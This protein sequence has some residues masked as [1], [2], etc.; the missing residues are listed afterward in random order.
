MHKLLGIICPENLNVN[1]IDRRPTECYSFHCLQLFCLRGP[2]S[3]AEKIQLYPAI[4][5]NINK[6]YWTDR[7]I[8]ETSRPLA[9]LHL[10]V[11]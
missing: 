5:R 9:R 4:V 10:S 6:L 7:S 3:T 11:S 8:I 1:S 2:F